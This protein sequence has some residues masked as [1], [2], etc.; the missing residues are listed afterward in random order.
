MTGLPV[1]SP[2]FSSE[3]VR[4]MDHTI[5]S[6]NSF[7]GKTAL[8]SGGTSGI[9]LAAAEIFLVGGASVMLM[10]RDTTRGQ[11]ALA[12][13]SAGENA[14]FV[15]GDVRHAVDCQR[16]VEE[17]VRAFDG[18]DILVNSAG[19]YAEGA[20]DD[21]MEAVLDD[22]ITTNIKGTF[23]LTQAVLP[24]LRRAR[25]NIVNVASDA[26]LRGNYFC[27]AYAA[28]KGAVIAFTRSLALELARDQVRVN[29]VAP[30]DV[31]TP[32]TERQ[33]SPHLPRAEQLHEMA[34][35][36]PLGRI[37]TPHEAAAVIAFLTSDAASWVTGSVYCVDGG[38]TA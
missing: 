20:L 10:G 24:H 16:A 26:G 11:A 12:Q 21:L 36:Y 31:L 8:I 3:D 19:I 35:I 7:A 18:I 30:A 25:G 15:C 28:T 34:A 37:G 4:Y 17:T 14:H 13:L 22:L 33:L 23:H 32:L 5:F 27:A 38:L 6:A 9:G 29:A 1:G 2:V